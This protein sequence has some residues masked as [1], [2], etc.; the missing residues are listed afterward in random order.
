[1]ENRDAKKAARYRKLD[2][3]MNCMI[4]GFAVGFLYECVYTVWDYKTHPEFYAVN[5]APWYT[6][7]VLFGAVV[8]AVIAAGVLVKFLIRKKK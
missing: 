7:L 4:I 6:T 8:A 5:S 1:M 3:L 2:T